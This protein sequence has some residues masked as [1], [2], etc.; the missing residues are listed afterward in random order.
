MTEHQQYIKQKQPTRSIGELN[1]KSVHSILK[2]TIEP[3]KDNQE[4]KLPN[5]VGIADILRYSKSEDNKQEAF[6]IQQSQ[7]N[8]LKKKLDYYMDNNISTTIVYPV[9][10]SKQIHWIDPHTKSVADIRKSQQKNNKH[11]VF[12]ELYKIQKYIPKIRLELY[13]IEV[14]EF[15]LLDGYGKNNKNK[16]TKLDKVP[17]RVLGKTVIDSLDSFNTFIPAELLE[18][19]KQFTQK[20]FSKLTKTPIE[21]ARTQLLVMSN[22]GAVERIGYSGNQIVYRAKG[23]TECGKT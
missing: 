7:F 11:S 13:E 4:V 1:E 2:N 21:L 8:R 9:I 14:I 15:K 22:I 3:N 23:G 10:V 19:K 5:G 20:E 6:E 18:D 17:T 16:A 12:K